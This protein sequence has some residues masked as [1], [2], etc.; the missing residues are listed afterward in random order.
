MKM[1]NWTPEQWQK[2]DAVVADVYARAAADAAEKVQWRR[3]KAVAEMCIPPRVLG[4]LATAFDSEARRLLVDAPLVT[5]LAGNPGNGKTVAA[6][7]WLHE[8]PAGLFVAAP[9]LSRWDRYNQEKMAKLLSAPALVVD[10]LGT[11]YQDAKGHFAAFIDEIVNH[12]YDH[13]LPMVATTNL[14]A[15]DFKVRYGE[16][17]VD[18]IREAGDFRSVASPSFRGGAK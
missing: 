10:D 1:P 18:R 4:I 2:H 14:D 16:R 15:A 6:C 8:R 12:R 3:D 5:V 11:E 17:V 9:A 13:K 7:A